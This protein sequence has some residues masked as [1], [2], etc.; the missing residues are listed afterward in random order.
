MTDNNLYKSLHSSTLPEQVVEQIEQLIIDGHLRQGD[1]LPAERFLSERLSVSR[2]VVREA[3]KSLQEKG[4]VEVRPG[5]GTFVHN[6]MS[7]IMRESI[8]R[9][10]LFD[11]QHGIANLLEVRDILEPEIAALAANKATENDI[12]DL[13]KAVKNVEESL[14]DNEAFIEADRDF[15]V[16]LAQAT[17]NQLVVNLLASVIELL[18]E[19]RRKI[20]ESRSEEPKYR[21]QAYHKQILQAIVS[22]DPNLARTT[23]LDHM[24]QVR[25]DS[26]PNKK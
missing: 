1:Q 19:E 9:M 18:P 13:K 22:R 2:S 7:K 5:V 8:E 14:T 21:A 25:D 15:H 3:V 6:G 12:E 17:Q 10:V 23:M 16:T 20:F 4:L 26:L 11:G 24:K